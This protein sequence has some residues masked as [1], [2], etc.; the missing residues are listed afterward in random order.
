VVG[1]D[2]AE[3]FSHIAKVIENQ[4]RVNSQLAAFI[5]GDMNATQNVRVG[6]LSAG[7]EESE[8]ISVTLND[9][10]ISLIVS[11][12]E[13]RILGKSMR[14]YLEWR[15]ASLLGNDM[16]AG[17]GAAKTL[18]RRELAAL[19]TVEGSSTV[20]AVLAKHESKVVKR[21]DREG[22]FK[23]QNVDPDALDLYPVPRT[24][25]KLDS[26][27]LQHLPSLG[28]RFPTSATEMT[29]QLEPGDTGRV[30]A[31]AV[32]EI[33]G[34]HLYVPVE[35]VDG[36]GALPA[37]DDREL[38]FVAER[39][40]AGAV[41]WYRNPERHEGGHPGAVARRYELGGRDRL[42]F[43]DFV[44][45]YNENG[46]PYLEI[47]ELHGIEADTEPKKAGIGMW[48]EEIQRADIDTNARVEV[49]V[50]SSY[51]VLAGRDIDVLMDE[52][53]QVNLVIGAIRR[54]M[55]ENPDA[56]AREV[57]KQVNAALTSFFRQSKDGG[58]LQAAKRAKFTS[59][60]MQGRR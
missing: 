12:V 8:T 54:A 31:D 14:S 29:L 28:N 42:F 23:Q 3:M 57:Q 39:L 44:F 13:R 33:M 47:V 45:V 20:G 56:T 32:A 27:V 5:A 18:S 16:V 58:A 7:S 30:S 60:V 37:L 22:L 49:K 25:G 26:A 48:P 10:D 19:L 9:R 34:R 40:Q 59:V 24:L 4:V 2:R 52:H 15:A 53:Q 51:S 50:L 46:Q 35:G 38:E 11:E 55:Q 21:L 17:A 1:E 41:A 43:P 36:L 6:N